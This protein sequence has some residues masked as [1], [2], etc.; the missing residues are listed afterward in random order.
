[1]E[2]KFYSRE[3]FL[4]DE[5]PTMRE[6]E[7]KKLKNSMNSYDEEFLKEYKNENRNKQ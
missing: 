4:N 7:A 1:M 6:D 2:N 5:K 3:G